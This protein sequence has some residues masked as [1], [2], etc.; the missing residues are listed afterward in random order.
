MTASM[1]SLS[2]VLAPAVSNL[3][4]TELPAVLEQIAW[5]ADSREAPQCLRT[6]TGSSIPGL[7]SL[8]CY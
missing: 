1:E 7:S 4:R 2:G 3:I 8:G 6:I 5:R